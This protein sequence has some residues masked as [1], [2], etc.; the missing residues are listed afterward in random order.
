[1]ATGKAGERHS[2]ST[3][4]RGAHGGV[5]AAA[6]LLTRFSRRHTSALMLLAALVVLRVLLDVWLASV[7]SEATRWIDLAGRQRMLVSRIAL[8][9][10]ALE[11]VHPEQERSV[12][13]VAIREDASALV[14]AQ[15][16]LTSRA[17]SSGNGAAFS[18]ELWAL[19]FQDP[20]RLDA[21]ID[22]YYRIALRVAKEKDAD[23]AIDP[24]DLTALIGG[25]RGELMRLLERAAAL[26]AEREGHR[27]IR[28]I[29]ASALGAFAVLLALAAIHWTAFRPLTIAM[30]REANRLAEAEQRYRVEAR[31]SRFGV[32]LQE[33]FEMVDSEQGILSVVARACGEIE[34]TMPM[35]VLLADSSRA[36]LRVAATSPG[37][38]GAGCDVATPWDCPA[39][40]RG[41]T[42]QFTTAKGLR[43]CPR[44]C[45]RATDVCA[46]YCVPMTFMGSPLGV[47][48]ALGA[49][50][51]GDPALFLSRL[52]TVATQASNRLGA[53]RSLAQAQLQASTDPLTGL[54]N[55][56]A[57]EAAFRE[58]ESSGHPFTLAVADLDH[59]KRLNDAHG[60]DAGDLA[61]RTFA[62]VVRECTRADD[63]AVRYG[64][65]EFVLVLCG[66]KAVGG[67]RVLD[68]IRAR[69]A[70]ATLSGD[71]PRFTA[72]FGI[73]DPL[74]GETLDELVSTA[75][76]AL[77]M[78]KAEGRDRVVVAPRSRDAEVLATAGGATDD[79]PIEPASSLDIAPRCPSSTAMH[80]GDA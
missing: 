68:R 44:L 58:L 12:A 34:A 60:H 18:T 77:L 31:K 72:S 36:H 71:T 16:A 50:P 73:A 40:K 23:S 80:V 15:R 43:A 29:L 26:G 49:V 25:A 52:E 27:R 11:S 1:M 24:A 30:L 59:F 66:M 28:V 19:E 33:A 17:R 62:K 6:A 21:R 45:D 74:P 10:H 37:A 64:G 57:F 3:A 67:V 22:A 14:E 65:E 75:D 51:P 35:E 70:A 9:A 56:R 46:A 48:H 63:I 53:A 5:T 78:A 13:A 7:M 4:G 69:L 42:L 20:A 41:R 47:I 76:A 32:D 61:L 79:S 54:H 39:V 2:D 38:G 55:R 8:N